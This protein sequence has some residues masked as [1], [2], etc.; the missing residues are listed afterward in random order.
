MSAQFPSLLLF[1]KCGVLFTLLA[2][3]FEGSFEGPLLFQPQPI[4]PSVMYRLPLPRSALFLSGLRIPP[5]TKGKI[6]AA[7]FGS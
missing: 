2:P 7:F 5:Y 4:H 6:K 1:L 3:I